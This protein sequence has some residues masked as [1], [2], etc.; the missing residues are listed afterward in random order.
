MNRP[1]R[2]NS[3]MKIRASQ[4][5]RS[6]TSLPGKLLTAVAAGIRPATASSRPV[7]AIAART[8]FRREWKWPDGIF[9][10]TTSAIRIAARRH[11]FRIKKSSPLTS[12]VI[13]EHSRGRQQTLRSR[14]Q[15]NTI[16]WSRRANCRELL[17]HLVGVREQHWRHVD[18]ERLRGLK[19]DNHLERGGLLNGQVSWLSTLQELPGVN[20]DLA[21]GTR[22]A[23]SIAD[24]ATGRDELTPVIHHWDGM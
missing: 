8:N 2:H 15:G 3:T 17:D 12:R 4:P 24:Q 10:P 9:Y 1:S 20:S 18:A 11:C 6:S 13:L 23:R 5:G 14:G 21:K 22:K 16:V 19:I 7:N